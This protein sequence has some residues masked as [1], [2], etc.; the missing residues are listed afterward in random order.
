MEGYP[1][2]NNP[3]IVEAIIDIRVS[4]LVDV[5]ENKISQIRTEAGEAYQSIQALRDI[6]YKFRNASFE[7]SEIII[8]GYLLQ[9]LDGN[10][11]GQF[12][13]DGFTFNRLYPYTS[14]TD[15][16]RNAK[17]LWEIYKKILSPKQVTRV[18]TRYINQMQFQSSINEISQFLK[19]AP[20]MSMSL[21]A[22]TKN[23]LTRAT[24]ENIDKQIAATI[25]QTIEQ[26]VTTGNTIVNLDIDVFSQRKF[27]IQ[28]EQQM[29]ETLEDLRKMKN[30]IFFESITKSTQNIFNQ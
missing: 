8:R 28:N 7:Q 16:S 1:V 26:E 5:N 22:D 21:K 4:P 9:S 11:K 17:M 23:F 12:R 2:L 6:N 15:I 3:P 10:N 13:V 20:N 29:W 18:S 24:I 19:T 14:W 25:T 30:D 27:T